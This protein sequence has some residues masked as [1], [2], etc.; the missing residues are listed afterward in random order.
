MMTQILTGDRIGKQGT[1]R[2]GCSAVLLDELGQSV[3]LTR[4]V[5]NG[6]WCLPGGGVE[7][8]ES[9][10]EACARE[11]FEET[12]LKVRVKRLTG[13]YSSPDRIIVYPGGNKIQV[14]SLNFFVE[15]IGGKLGL[16]DETTEA[17]FVPVSE[18][19]EMKL[20]HSHAERIRDAVV[21]QAEAFIK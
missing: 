19:V 9:M 16:S 3:L 13:V 5:D 17:R 20:F 21:R 1:I 6:E 18:A 2:L 12:G 7:P 4:R 14:V 11:F 8:G 15:K 10:A